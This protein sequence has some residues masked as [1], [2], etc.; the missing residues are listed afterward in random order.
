MRMSSEGLWVVLVVAVASAACG[1]STSTPMGGAPAAA[2]QSA[3]AVG[4][5]GTSATPVGGSAKD[6]GSVAKDA[7][8]AAKD[9]G[10]VA[11]DAG[12]STADGGGTAKGADAGSTNADAATAGALSFSSM[13]FADGTKIA[14]KY[15]CTGPSPD[16]RWSGAPSATK[17]FAIVL[18]DVTPGISQGFLHWVIYDIPASVSSLDEG[19]AVGAMPAQPAGAK[20]AA[21]WNGTLGFNGPCAPSGTNTYELTLYA[22]DVAS[23]PG[24]SSS[25]TGADVVTAIDAHKLASAKITIT[26]MP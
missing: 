5:G 19:V 25:S 1:K 6:A 2:G 24:L 26:S 3:A 11:K 15:R 22:E 7:G 21:I 23:L 9:A 8:S 13:A 16:L 18:K 4:S 12:K 10:S 20:Q 17:S 14:T